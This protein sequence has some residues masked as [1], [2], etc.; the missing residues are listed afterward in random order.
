[1]AARR[2]SV[3]STGQQ[4]SPALRQ[5]LQDSVDANRMALNMRAQSKRTL[6]RTLSKAEELINKRMP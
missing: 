3:T 1:M 6:S 4:T 5:A 2:T